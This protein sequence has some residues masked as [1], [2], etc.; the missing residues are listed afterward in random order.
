[1]PQYDASFVLRASLRVDAENRGALEKAVEAVVRDMLADP[2][3]HAQLA[4]NGALLV[5][6]G[7]R[8]DNVATWSVEVL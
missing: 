7:L 3:L 6:D 4:Q 2:D 8:V 5:S 1:M